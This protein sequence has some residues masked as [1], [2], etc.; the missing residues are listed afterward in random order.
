MT[1]MQR[2]RALMAQA[3]AGTVHGTWEDLFRTIDAGTYATDYQQG[4]T[5]ELDLGQTLGVLQMEISDFDFDDKADGSGKA[6]ITMI[7]QNLMVPAVR[8][9]LSLSGESGNYVVGTGTIGG[10]K[11]SEIRAWF[12]N[13]VYPAIPE[14]VRNRI[15]RV[16]KAS[17]SYDT[18][19]TVNNNDITYDYVFCPSGREAGRANGMETSYQDALYTALNTSQR[20]NKGEKWGLRSAMEVRSRMNISA[21]G[22]ISNNITSRAEIELPTILCFCVG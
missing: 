4:E 16:I 11:E 14:K 1:L 9:N 20:R 15:I 17:V 3:K 13:T 18:T 7:S 22:S 10:W 21:S 5:I 19:G 12:V 6:P 2:R 8:F